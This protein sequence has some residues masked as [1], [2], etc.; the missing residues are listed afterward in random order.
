MFE[1]AVDRSLISPVKDRFDIPKI[2]ARALA[3]VYGL[4][5]AAATGADHHPE[6][7]TPALF[8]MPTSVDVMHIGG[9]GANTPEKPAEHTESVIT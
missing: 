5:M 1:K 7:L 2:L 8:V 6:I 9:M 4:W 3:S